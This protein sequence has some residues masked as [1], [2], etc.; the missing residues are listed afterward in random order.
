MIT[1]GR[2]LIA[3][4]NTMREQRDFCNNL[5]NKVIRNEVTKALALERI[6]DLVRSIED[7][8]TVLTEFLNEEPDEDERDAMRILYGNQGFD[9]AVTDQEILRHM[10]EAG[11][12]D[13]NV[14]LWININVNGKD[15]IPL[16][17]NLYTE[18]M[19]NY[20]EI[21]NVKLEDEETSKTVNKLVNHLNK[22]VKAMVFE[23]FGRETESSTSVIHDTVS[24][25]LDIGFDFDFGS[26]ILSSTGLVIAPTVLS[27]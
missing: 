6:D 23:V 16:L 7:L 11:Q 26:S 10:T 27:H 8:G 17:V 15:D 25:K 19:L 20:S 18:A 22:D 24:N 14:S 21:K 3:S 1:I 12:E 2:C 5:H 13:Q 9:D 4:Y